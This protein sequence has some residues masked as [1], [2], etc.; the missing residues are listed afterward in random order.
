MEQYFVNTI[1][2]A[3]FL[4]DDVHTGDHLSM[5]FRRVALSK[6]NRLYVGVDLT[7][8]T[9][10]V[11]ATEFAEARKIIFVEQNCNRLVIIH[12]Q[13][14]TQKSPDRKLRGNR[15]GNNSGVRELCV[16]FS[17]KEF[18][19]FLAK[20]FTLLDSIISKSVSVVNSIL[21]SSP[22]S[23]LMFGGFPDEFGGV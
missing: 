5:T 20:S 7:E 4:F 19:V 3:T 15:S 11:Y 16:C 18:G 13:I 14:I 8:H 6:N 9:R 1:A 17:R 23:P 12:N 10:T 22:V 21:H 2:T